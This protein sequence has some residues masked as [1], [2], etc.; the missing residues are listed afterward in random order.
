LNIVIADIHFLLNCSDMPVNPET[1]S[2]TYGPF[3]TETLSS[4]ESP[5]SIDLDIEIN[6]FPDIRKM[7]KIFDTRELW[8]MFSSGNEYFWVD[9][10]ESS[11]RESA[12][13][14]RF[15]RRPERVAVYCRE[16]L[17]S[18]TNG[19]RMINNP[20]VHPLDQLLMM[21]TLAERDGAILHA[22]AVELDGKGF[23][24]PGRS[25]A[26]KTTISRIFSARGHKLLSDDRVV[27]RKIKNE[28]Y[29]FGTPW[30]GDAG[31]AENRKLP[32][33]GIF[34]LRQSSVNRIEKIKP[35]AAAERLM[36]I[37]SIP[38]FDEK[39]MSGILSFCEDLILHV[40]AYELYFKPDT[41]VVDFLEKFISA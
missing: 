2:K 19:Q 10:A 20:F 12:C 6:K 17:I 5:V 36:P 8:S 29:A 13:I 38:W 32:L 4:G 15:Q 11:P 24:L 16:R 23:L 18:E 34:F 1:Y 40:P 28:F 21:Y 31:I 27:A 9:A 3:I 35:S 26:G 7:T 33:K 39:T 22:C 14:A 25:G 30:A 37:A 41:E